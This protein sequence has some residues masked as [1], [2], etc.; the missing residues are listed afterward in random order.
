MGILSFLLASSIG[1]IEP[2]IKIA[3]IDTGIKNHQVKYLCKGFHYDFTKEGFFDKINHGSIIIDLVMSN[4]DSDKYCI[5]LFKWTNTYSSSG[6]INIKKA[7]FTIAQTDIRYINMSFSGIDSYDKEEFSM[8]NELVKQNKKIFVA[9]GNDNLDLTKSCN[10]F[11]AC[12]KIRKN[13]FVV[14]N[15]NKEKK[16]KLSNYNGPINRKEYGSIYMKDGILTGT[17]FSSAI[18]LSKEVKKDEKNM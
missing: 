5:V 11:P 4:L 12:Y 6:T 14:G 2:R 3:I 17:S 10:V 15:Y 13:Y 9:A 18:S 7:L 8:L 16:E 1:Y